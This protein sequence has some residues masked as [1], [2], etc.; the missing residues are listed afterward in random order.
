MASNSRYQP[1]PQRDSFDEPAFSHAPPSY[2]ATAESPRTEDDNVPD[3]FKAC[4]SPDT[5]L[6]FERKH[7]SNDTVVQFGGT[8]AEAALPI[9][10]QFIRKVYAIL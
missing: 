7:K 6:S 9:R 2:Q 5:L 10:M 1:A 3:D 4:P 8:V